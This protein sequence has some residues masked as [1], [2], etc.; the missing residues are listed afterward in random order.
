MLTDSLRARLTVWYLLMLGLALAVFAGLLYLSLSRNLYRHHDGEL[1]AEAQRLTT[2]LHGSVLSVDTAADS[3]DRARPLTQIVML[4]NGQGDLVFRSV[5]LRA[6]EPNIGQHEALVHAVMNAQGGPQFFTATLE[7]LGPVRFICTPLSDRLF[8]QLGQPL[9]DVAATLNVVAIT[10]AVLVPLVLVLTSFGGW[11][12]AKRALAPVSAIDRSLATI[13]ATDL[14][15]RL[16]I[17]TSD[18]ELTT[19]IGGI[20]SLLERVDRA[21]RSL[22]EFAADVSHQLQ[23]PLTVMKG[24]VEVALASERDSK[25]YREVLNGVAT[26]VNDVVAI[27]SDLR[28]VMLADV[29]AHIGPTGPVNLS[30]IWSEGADIIRALG[31]ASSVTVSA[32]IEAGVLVRGNASR[33]KQVL[34]NVGD[35]AVKYT[36]AGGRVDITLRTVD[37]CAVLAVRDTGLGIAAE[38]VPRIF[39]RFYRVDS[40]CAGVHGTG[41]GLAIVKRIVDAHHGAVDVTSDMGAGSLFTIHLPMSTA[42]PSEPTIRVR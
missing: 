24:S 39:D 18:S 15:R 4:R 22:R 37:G 7:R 13:Q 14:S 25:V 29:D 34:L 26:E 21:F 30:D 1:A 35:N 8:L 42:S 33:L 31:E 27:V 9:G 32:D 10:S 20:N 3:I 36:P 23:T 28:A 41:L 38:H 19:L 12:I 5:L 40:T 2:A 11:V 6:S 16:D 17:R